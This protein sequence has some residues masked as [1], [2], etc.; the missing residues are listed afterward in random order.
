MGGRG[1]KLQLQR[2][3][4]SVDEDD[5]FEE[6][7]KDLQSPPRFREVTVLG[8]KFGGAKPEV[9]SP[10][11]KLLGFKGFRLSGPRSPTLSPQPSMPQ[12]APDFPD[13]DS[14]SPAPPLGLRFWLQALGVCGVEQE[15]DFQAGFR[16]LGV[17]CFFC[18]DSGSQASGICVC[19]L[20]W[21]ASSGAG[22]NA[23]HG[24]GPMYEAST[25]LL[26]SAGSTGILVLGFKRF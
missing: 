26:P 24:L 20:S 8:G 12:D 15:R 1:R 7:L 19:A 16:V 25:V 13:D 10:N 5:A 22:T 3:E 11:P 2:R 9:T 17:C 21:I 4:A 6:A 14:P 23:M 18:T